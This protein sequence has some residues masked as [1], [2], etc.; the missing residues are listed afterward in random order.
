M[1]FGFGTGT[2]AGAG[3]APSLAAL[4]EQSQR[5]NSSLV[6]PN[7]LPNIAL[8]LDQ[9]E[10]QSRRI[11]QRSQRDAGPSST[12]AS[13]S[14]YYLLASAGVN[15][16]RLQS[17]ID[18]V[19]LQG[20]FEPLLP[21][22]ETDVDG[23]LRHTHEQTII[24]S[25]EEG[26]RQT[27]SD[28]YRSLDNQ[29]RKDWEKQKDRL[30]EELG[31]HQAIGAGFGPAGPSSSTDATPRR[32]GTGGGFDRG[33]P[34][35]PAPS[36]TNS[37]ANPQS[38]LQL[39]SRM[40]RYDR[41]VRKLNDYRKQGHAFGLVS[42]FGEASVGAAGDSKS[43]QT[44]ETW[45]LLS[46]LVKERDVLNGEF[47]RKSLVQGQYSAAYRLQ[48]SSDSADAVQ[49]RKSIAEGARD[50]LEEQFMAYIE[51]TLASRPAEANLGGV[52]S[53]QNKIRAFLTVKYYKQGA[54]SNSSLE[55]ANSVPIW[56]RIYYLL[57]SGHAKEALEFA[58]ENEGHIQRLEKNFVGYFRDWLTSE[59]R[60]L[61]K[62]RRDAFVAEY[63]Q[64]IRYQSETSDPYKHALYKLIGRVD[65]TRRNVPGVTGTT[66][67]WLWFQLSLVRETVGVADAPQDKYGLND[68][69]ALLVKFGEGHFDPKGNRPLLYFQVL[70]L[71]GQFERAVAFLHQH[72]HFQ[73]DAVHFAIA[74]AYYGLL[75]IPSKA[76]TSDV[77]LLVIS[78][79]VAYLNFARLLQ[80]YTR[81]FI[82]SD[83]Q[84]A[85]QYLYLICLNGDLPKP[86]GPEQVNLCHEYVRELVMETRKYAELLGDV[87]SDGTKIPGMLERD[88]KL[89]MLDGEQSYLLG[90]VKAA[91]QRADQEKRF[92]EAILLYNLA[93]EYDSVI[94]VLNVELGNS[95]SLPS[96]SASGGAAAA[97]SAGGYFKNGTGSVSLAAGQEDVAKIARSI[98]E[99][100][101][102]SG[103][104]MTKRNWQT[105]EVLLR[106]KEAM[107]LY[108][109]GNLE[110]SLAT[111]EAV[112]IIPLQSNPEQVNLVNIIRSA[113]EFKELDESIV[114]NFDVI[115]LTT[116]NIIYKLYGALKES[117][118]GDVSRQ[119][120][121]M[122]LRAKARSLMMFAGM[123][124]YRLTSD[125]YAAL[126]RLDVYI[127]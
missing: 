114:R 64:R 109:Q 51:R 65:L 28:F 33:S 63:N 103:N 66:E 19:N 70:L 98:L 52:P 37:A 62:I 86:T 71:S 45:R 89:M 125:T 120:R 24:S 111:I 50:H 46:H 21:L 74:L 67:D 31:R 8:G 23:Y 15:A 121:M 96:T 26:R 95:L 5:L 79:D 53:I 75:R 14:A 92:S 18:N 39:H 110:L 102:R 12:S 13:G 54:W 40:M 1:S 4:L 43:A 73:A 47:Q 16:D 117:P 119:Q 55:I 87:R 101:G 44:T 104:K 108:E 72:S 68:L 25:I 36:S 29:M 127:A 122:D 118:F 22:S 9:I 48:Q 27:T 32:K 90:I 6:Q 35:T 2:G 77:D 123:L 57:R 81:A 112:N 107:V 94:S 10:H 91:A 85:L 59:D 116:M 126:T 84:E 88:L 38:A 58:V 17:T 56:A 34:K 20:T 42:Q 78:H 80:R 41:V 76:I 115:L 113:E 106:L 97:P 61:T 93:E 60:R 11:A 30:F 3:A 7:D 100:Y 99:H 105:C 124:R 82:Q 69:G 49:L 83:A